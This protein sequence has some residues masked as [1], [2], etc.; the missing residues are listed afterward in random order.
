MEA[1][2]QPWS[3]EKTKKPEHSL[4]LRFK[5]DAKVT[6]DNALLALET[7]EL[8]EITFNGRPVSNEPVGYFTDESIKT[9]ELGTVQQG[10][11]VLLLE[12]P[13][14]PESNLEWCYVLGDF[15]VEVHGARAWITEPVRS[16]D[17]GDWTRQGLPFYGANVTY[18]WTVDVE[19][20]E[21]A[22][23]I[24]KFR[25]PV[26]AVAVDG[27]DAGRI[28]L[29]PYRVELGRLSGRHTI[30]ITVFGNRFNSFGQVHC[31]IDAI[32]WSGPG[33]WRTQNAEFSYEYQLRRTGLLMAPVLLKK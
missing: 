27:K 6:A 1:F 23:E 3:V 22:I 32:G 12:M 8:C 5:F 31:S 4:R 18:E 2:A 20:G 21:Y 9:V 19:E 13:Y 16:L 24:D 25:A 29:L 17:F 30:S 7:P 33:A 26:I 10:D 14:M 28:A 11:N 15:G